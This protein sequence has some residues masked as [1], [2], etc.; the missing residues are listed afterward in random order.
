MT[1]DEKLHLFNQVGEEII[2][3]EELKDLLSSG[4]QLYAYDGFEPS[5]QMHIAQ[6]LMRAINI[7]RI[8]STGVKFKMLIGDWHALANNKLGGDLEKI[9]LVGQYFVEVWKACGLD[10]KNI[11]FVW[12]S[13]LVKDDTYW[14]LVLKIA[15]TNGIKRFIRTAEIMGRDESM[16]LSLA[17]LIY[18]AM[19]CADIFTLGARITQL[20]MDQ[21]KVNM[22][23]REVG[24]QLGFW[25]PVVVSHHMLLGL[26]TPTTQTDDKVK[27][28]IELKMSKSK[29]D[30]AIF[31]TD[32]Y[33]DIDRKLRKAWCPEGGI[34]ENPILEYCKYIVFGLHNSLTIERNEEHGGVV[35]Y[36]S[37]E[38]LEKEYAQKKIH[39][40]DLKAAVTTVLDTALEPIRSHF[41][42]DDTARNLLKQIQSFQVTR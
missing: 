8:T 6:A 30:S 21:R 27:R 19:Q 29:P 36:D 14:M 16:D 35:T 5:G 2:E 18:P 25:K 7:N 11:E 15:K 10:M 24:P 31:V 26:G 42:T 41:A 1:I 32:T 9:K 4:E 40:L 33:K 34:S 22:L 38:A 3:R 12:A 17:Q 23:G 39:P 13:D 28:T 37:Y 20:G